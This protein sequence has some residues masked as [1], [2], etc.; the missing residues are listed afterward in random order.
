M[1]TSLGGNNDGQKPVDNKGWEWKY[2]RGDI[3]SQE[4][5]RLNFEIYWNCWAEEF[6]PPPPEP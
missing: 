1:L 3:G 6:N 2:R 4:E 5:V